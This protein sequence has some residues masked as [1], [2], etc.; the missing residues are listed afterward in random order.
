M[1]HATN[2]F[3]MPYEEKQAEKFVS[4]SKRHANNELNNKKVIFQR[5]L[6]EDQKTQT[7]AVLGY[8]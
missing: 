8:D 2:A 4:F 5:H 7:I 6:R 3:K 1:T